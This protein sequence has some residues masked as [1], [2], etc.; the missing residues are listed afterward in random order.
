MTD[1]LINYLHSQVSLDVCQRAANNQDFEELPTHNQTNNTSKPLDYQQQIN[2]YKK[3]TELKK[4]PNITQSQEFN[5]RIS[6]V[7]E[8]AGGSSNRTKSSDFHTSLSSGQSA[9]NIATSSHKTRSAIESSPVGD[10]NMTSD[11]GGGGSGK[12]AKSKSQS[13]TYIDKQENMS[14]FEEK[15]TNEKTK[16]NRAVSQSPKRRSS[17]NV[18]QNEQ[19]ITDGPSSSSTTSGEGKRTAREDDGKKTKSN[20]FIKRLSM[21]FRSLSI[22]NNTDH[23]QHKPERADSK[24]LKRTDSEKK[25]EKSKEEIYSEQYSNHVNREKAMR[26]AIS[27]SNNTSKSSSSNNNNSKTPSAPSVNNHYYPVNYNVTSSTNSRSRSLQTQ[28]S[29]D[30]D[31]ESELFLKSL[32][33][34]HNKK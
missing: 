1:L 20:G 13:T 32:L 5:R 2:L 25:K 16:T 19:A 23:G 22:E 24:K 12:K 34:Q 10:K 8:K 31:I 26:E 33:A 21:R 4:H 9:G 3:Y 15:T 28:N 7:F 14:T 30:I 17:S 18:R 27:V 11:G 29:N 6:V